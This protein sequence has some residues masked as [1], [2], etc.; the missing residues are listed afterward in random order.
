MGKSWDYCKLAHAAKLAGG[1][2]KYVNLIF[3]NGYEQ[4]KLNGQIVGFGEGVLV[5]AA[6][7]AFAKA[8]AF[9]KSLADKDKDK[10]SA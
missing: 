9:V 2:E 10:R 4:G 3:E 6:V 7:F 8:V 1:P 5:A